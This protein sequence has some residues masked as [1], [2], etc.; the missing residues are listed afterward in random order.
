LCKKVCGRLHQTVTSLSK[1]ELPDR[2]T[3]GIEEI[4]SAAKAPKMDGQ[5]Y[6][7][8]VRGGKP[9]DSTFLTNGRKAIINMLSDRVS[10]E[11]IYR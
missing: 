10:S 5:G 4:L 3:E 2:Y 1:M 7:Y 11:L 9:F 8:P 6:L